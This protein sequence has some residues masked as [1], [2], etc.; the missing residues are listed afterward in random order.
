MIFILLSY[1]SQEYCYFF[2]PLAWQAAFSMAVND[3]HLLIF[4]P[5]CSS[6]S[7][8][9]WAGL[10]DLVLMNKT[11]QG[12]WMPL[13]KLDYKRQWL[14]SFSDS[15]HILLWKSKRE[16]FTWQE[17]KSWNQHPSDAKGWLFCYCHY[18]CFKQ[19][20]IRRDQSFGDHFGSSHSFCFQ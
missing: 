3:L 7:L 17:A 19:L 11:Q 14:P 4:M 9:I 5:M 13:W 1:F 2:S 16:R 12:C 6:F 8:C 18:C 20:F 15:F 10:S